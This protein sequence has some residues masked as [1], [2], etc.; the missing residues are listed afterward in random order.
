MENRSSS[1]GI[2]W[3]ESDHIFF[4]VALPHKTQGVRQGRRSEKFRFTPVFSRRAI[5]IME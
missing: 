4:F 2:F 3:S 1:R 5:L